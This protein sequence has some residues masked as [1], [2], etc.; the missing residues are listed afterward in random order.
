MNYHLESLISKEKFII[1]KEKWL[2]ALEFAKQNGWSPL[3]TILDFESELDLMWNEDQSRMYNLWM[4]LTCH[5]SCHEWEGSYTEKE[6]QII[7]D[8][9][10][11]ELM[12]SLEMSDEFAELA[13]FVAGISFRILKE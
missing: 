11:Y 13:Q 5:N 10:S 12:L 9:D 7:S 8:T 3:G 4:V 6:N 1:S 2:K